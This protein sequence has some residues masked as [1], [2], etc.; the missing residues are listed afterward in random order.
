MKGEDL[1]LV[2]G[3]ATMLALAIPNAW[4]TQGSTEEKLKPSQ[5]PA[6]VREAIKSNCPNCT[7][8]K[9][10]REVEN[11]V[12][13]YDIEFK[14]GQGEM[15]VADDGSVID[16]ETVVRTKDVPPPALEAILKGAAG[17]RIKQVARDEVRAELKDGKVIKLDSPKYLYEADL[18]KGKQ[19]AEIQVTPD[20]QVTEAPIWRAKG[21]KEN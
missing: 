15:D 12:T 14:T 2:L 6:A 3:V 9:A 17:G 10:T 7:I 19:L 13:L 21:T 18:E 16:R 5:L 1:R 4:A 11:G 8:N 20:G